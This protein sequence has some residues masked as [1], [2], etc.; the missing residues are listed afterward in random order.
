MNTSDTQVL[1]DFDKWATN[2]QHPVISSLTPE[3]YGRNLGSSYGGIHGTLVHIYA[4]QWIWLSRWNGVSPTS[5]IGGDDI[6]TLAA[7]MDRW[8]TLRSA[9][10]CVIA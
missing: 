7:L 8:G 10:Q 2:E 9:F 6:P 4:A 5:L 1:Y 3:Q